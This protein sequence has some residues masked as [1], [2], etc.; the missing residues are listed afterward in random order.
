MAIGTLANYRGDRVRVLRLSELTTIDNLTG[1]TVV[2]VWQRA[3][4]RHAFA[5]TLARRTLAIMGAL[6]AVLAVVVWF[7]VQL[8]LRRLRGLQDAIEQRSPDDL[9]RIK[10]PVQSEVSGI[11]ETL[12]G[13]LKQVEDSIQAHQAFISDAAHQ[14]RNP[15]A[16]M[17]SLAETLPDVQEPEQRLVRE[18]ELIASARATARLA[19]SLLSLERLRYDGLRTP[20]LIELNQVA[21]RVCSDVGPE[22]LSRNIDFEFDATPERLPVIGDA[23][24]LGEAMTNLIDNAL[25]HGGPHLSRI[26]VRTRRDDRAAHLI[27]EDDGCG[28]PLNK[29]E[30]AFRRFSQLESGEGSGLG[31]SIVE[32]IL[33]SHGGCVRVNAVEQGTSIL[34]GIPL[35]L[36]NENAAA[37]NRIA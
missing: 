4:D 18:Q 24:L 3:S 35:A 6:M 26:S 2:T 22:I 28:L 23:V 29:V 25:R 30:L 36:T 1:E 27:I 19:E 20:E 13:L 10:R 15:T 7:G 21:E 11:V 32:E 5:L 16:A 34:L 8:G 12:N 37:P 17:L 31:L 33:K 14:L 9:S